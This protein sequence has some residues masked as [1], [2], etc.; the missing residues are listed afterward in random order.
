[1]K[2]EKG[3]EE[4]EN[5]NE[6]NTKISNRKNERA[7]K[8]SFFFFERGRAAS[9]SLSFS[10]SLANTTHIHRNTHKLS[11]YRHA[12]SGRKRPRKAAFFLCVFLPHLF[13]FEAAA[14]AS[15]AVAALKTTMADSNPASPLACLLDVT[16]RSA[17]AEGDAGVVSALKEKVRRRWKRKGAEEA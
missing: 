11:L 16:Y 17:E 3:R 1:M 8:S 12:L 6:K 15:R 9:C 13:F 2:G 4:M 7:K 5:V 14:A 10:R